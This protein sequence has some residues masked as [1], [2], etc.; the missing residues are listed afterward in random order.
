MI[1]D[2]INELSSD[3][4]NIYEG[5]EQ[6]N[7]FIGGAKPN[8]TPYT[9]MIPPPNVTGNLHVGH[10][11]TM[12]LQDTLIRWKR[13][14]G[15]DT[16]WMPGTDH[17]GIA[18]Q[19][20]VERK[21][22]QEGLSRHD[23]GRDKFI[24][25]V[26]KW[27]AE[28]GGSITKQLRRLGASLD[29]S[30]ERFTLDEKFSLAVQQA[31][32]KLFDQGLI[33][34]DKRLVNWDPKLKSAISD[35]EVKNQETKG[36]LWYIRY[37]IL[38][39]KDV[40]ITIATTRPETM[41]G[42]VAIA[43]HPSDSRYQSLISQKAI[44]PLTGRAIPIIADE[45]SDP[46]KGTGA[47]KITPAHDFND[48]A[49]GTRHNLPMPSILDTEA[50]III[51]EIQAEFVE[52]PGVSNL[53]FVQS[54]KG[55]VTSAAREL[56]IAELQNLGFIEKIEPHIS[57]IPYAER[58]G[59]VVEPLL[60][61]Q[62][63]CNAA[64]LAKPAIKAVE[65]GAVKFVPKQW[66][67]TYF[68][69]MENIQP[70][71]ISRQLWWGHRIPAWYGPDGKVFV[72]CT[73]EQALD[74][75][76][77]YYNKDVKL[78]QDEDVLD[79]WFSSALWPFA[80]L[81]WPEN[82]SDL[83]RY[84]PTNVLV[85][86]FDIIFFWVSRMLMMGL[87]F[88]QEVPFHTIFIHGLILDEHGQKMSKTKGNVIDP[89]EIMDKYG[90]DTLRWSVCALTG[91]GRNLKLS[92]TQ[93]EISR[94]FITK[95]NNACTFCQINNI[96]PN[97]NFAPSKVKTVFCR[98][99]L[100]EMNKAISAATHALEAYRFDDY[101][102]SLYRFIW[103]IFCDWFIELSKPAL[104]GEEATEVRETG[105]YVLGVILRLLHP[106]IPFATEKNWHKMGFGPL[107][108]LISAEW[109]SI[110]EVENEEE[111]RIE[112][113]WVIR[114]ITA[115]RSIRAEM[116]VPHSTK[117]TAYLYN[118]SEN[119]SK[120]VNDWSKYIQQLTKA[121]DIAALNEE[122]PE[123]AA[124][125]VIDE[126]T[127]VIP[128][129]DLIDPALERARLDKELTKAKTQLE[130]LTQ[131]LQNKDFLSKAPV[132]V[133]Q[134]RQERIDALVKEVAQLQEALDRIK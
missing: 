94:S 130:K 132:N 72:A 13:M 30:R 68:A 125:A 124:Q 12:T 67:N 111:A 90:A 39:R 98:W 69:W 59:A 9:I 61:T 131:Q 106:V 81:G 37:P 103:N 7:S 1:K 21:L 29:W 96:L 102:E 54:L 6:S 47:V 49:V 83:K 71:C 100:A 104:T 108:S 41:L 78:I 84:Y 117:V 120:R 99:L 45:Y 88:M 31:F 89:L 16:L 23:L 80:T 62:W 11:L 112:V 64:E 75:A 107:H 63:F 44:V 91:P 127:L 52:V 126:A 33:Y 128:L 121:S 95:I 57:Q 3:E 26:W 65:S 53:E 58:G 110:V 56:I 74:M 122:I 32:V 76:K 48:F 46:E 134:E 101:T 43:V 42:D 38:S 18:T 34:R 2:N 24:E 66:E 14:Q 73:E 5:W 17:A 79:T 20:M 82:T 123:G 115:I 85:T 87:H 86:G 119:N 36:S 35:L 77:K 116:N 50:K 60:T 109:P 8:S 129:A 25:Q 55:K 118:A 28:S 133:V 105:A 40:F 51:E 27:K 22:S 19:M 70:W 114:V 93:I 97:P 4:Q 113:E 15:H 92:P 10:A